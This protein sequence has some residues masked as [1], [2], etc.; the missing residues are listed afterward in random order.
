MSPLDFTFPTQPALTESVLHGLWQDRPVRTVNDTAAPGYT[1]SLAE[2]RA[3]LEEAERTIAEQ[4]DRIECLEAQ[5][6]TD[7]LTG[8]LNRRGFHTVFRRELAAGRRTGI[9][10]VMVMIDL[11]GFK[12]IND[13][14]GHLAGDAYLQQVARALRDNVRAHDIVARLGGDE[15]VV[16]LIGVDAEQGMARAAA[17]AE[18]VR[19]Q[20]CAWNGEQLPLR[21]SFGPEPFGPE[22]KADDVL[23]RADVCMYQVKAKR[24]KAA[25]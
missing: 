1:L 8:L 16:L 25:R 18:T 4:R 17:L 10:G 5:A 12:A 3:R 9:G 21:A 23:R 2:M 20:A 24:R 11:D 14:H 22:D 7:E 19:N 13:R 15:F 6:M